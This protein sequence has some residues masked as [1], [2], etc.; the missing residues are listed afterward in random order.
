M[1]NQIKSSHSTELKK[2]LIC[3]HEKPRKLKSKAL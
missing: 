2:S 3:A 1:T